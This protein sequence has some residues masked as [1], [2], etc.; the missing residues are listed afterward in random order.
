MPVVNVDTGVGIPVSTRTDPAESNSNIQRMVSTNQLVRVSQTPTISAG[1]IYAAKDVIGTL[2]TFAGAARFAGG[3]GRLLAVTLVDKD[4]ERADMDLILFDTAPT[5]A[6][7]NSPFDPTDAELSN[8]VGWV[9][10]GGGY[11]SDFTDNAVAHIDLDMGYVLAATSMFG[12]LVARSTP[13]YTATT[14]LVVTLT[15]AVD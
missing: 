1:A 11:Y 5:V 15:F 13:T 2:L 12:V 8:C 3:G 7:D 14:D 4:Q 9:P 6:A 10:I